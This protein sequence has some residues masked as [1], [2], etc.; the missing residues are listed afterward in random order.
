MGKGSFGQVVKAFDHEERCQ[1]A[2]KIIKN[3]KPFLNQA[4]I[5]VKLLEMMNRADAENK[6]YI[7]GSA[8]A[9]YGNTAVSASGAAPAP[10]HY[11]RSR[12]LA[13]QQQQQHQQAQQG[14]HLQGSA[15]HLGSSALVVGGGGGHKSYAPASLPLD[16]GSHMASSLGGL[17]IPDH[18]A[19]AAMSGS[20]LAHNLS[21]PPGGGVVG[22]GSIG[23]MPVGGAVGYAPFSVNEAML[24]AAAAASSGAGGSVGPLGGGN[25]LGVIGGPI[26]VGSVS[27]V[28]PASLVVGGSAAAVSVGVGVSSHHLIGG[29]GSSISNS[30][31][32][33]SS[34]NG[35]GGGGA[36][37]AGPLGSGTVGAGSGS[38]S[39]GSS[40][41]S[42]GSGIVSSSSAKGHGRGPPGAPSDRDESSPMVGVCVQPSP[43]IIH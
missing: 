14:Q 8:A 19:P 7:G 17:V 20:F 23:G 42:G 24:M 6:Y 40:V 25:S 10:S 39:G 34:T 35:G 13:Q 9:R 29:T 3:K 36:G 2:I 37:L 21:M 38:A 43:V 11:H 33:S 18:H 12:Y 32:S 30:S 31:S 1:V 22:P 5:E 27:T 26:G 41:G 16:L 15:S 28:G 4:Q